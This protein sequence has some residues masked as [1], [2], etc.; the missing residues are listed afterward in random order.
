MQVRTHAIRMA[1]ENID[2]TIKAADAILSQFDLARR[3]GFCTHHHHSHF[4][5]N[6]TKKKM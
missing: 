2:K 1:H 3:V 5:I 4:Q 6:P